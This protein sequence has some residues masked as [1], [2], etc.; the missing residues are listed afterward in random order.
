MTR[1]STL[2]VV[3]LLSNS[4][5]P[6]EAQDTA[7]PCDFC[8]TWTLDAEATMAR[9]EVTEGHET[10]VLDAVLSMTFQM[11]FSSDGIACMEV[12]RRGETAV[13]SVR[14]ELAGE[15]SGEWRV[16][17][18]PPNAEPQEM[19]VRLDGGSLVVRQPTRPDEPLVFRRV[20]EDTGAQQWC[21]ERTEVTP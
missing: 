4:A 17:N 20:A 19:W 2:A 11:A 21:A 3:L 1:F 16:R 6:A 14:W 9:Q 18:I 7:P 5:L 15:D 8:G 10:L 12:Q 13:E